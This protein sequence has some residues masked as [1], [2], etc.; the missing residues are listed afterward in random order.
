MSAVESSFTPSQL[1]ILGSS[2]LISD[3]GK[4][5][6]RLERHVQENGLIFAYFGVNGSTATA[7]EDDQT[8]KKWRGF[9]ERNGARG[10]VV[11]NVF[12]Y[13]AT[14]VNEL[15]SVADPVGA[16]N[17]AHIQQIISDADVLV[18]CWGAR[19]KLPKRLRKHLD[20]LM[21]VILASGKPVKVFGLT[22]SGDP[23]HPQMLGYATPL[24]PYEQARGAK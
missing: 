15:A 21:A 1:Q 23:L 2:A 8:V 12:G 17:A 5:R 20:D 3:C 16:E 14:D 18:P 6:W 7:V 13:R 9:S 24:V 10:F 19:G 11:G 22:T 4:Y